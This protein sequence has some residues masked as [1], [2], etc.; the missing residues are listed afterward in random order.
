MYLFFHKKIWEAKKK[1]PSPPLLDNA[2][3]VEFMLLDNQPV[4]GNK[5][6]QMGGCSSEMYYA[7][8]AAYGTVHTSQVSKLLIDYFEAE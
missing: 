3:V 1:K 6:G 7:F 2:Y 8:V 4:L 5:V